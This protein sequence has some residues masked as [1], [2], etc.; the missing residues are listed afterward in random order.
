MKK[1]ALFLFGV[2]SLGAVSFSALA[3][4]SSQ[5]TE[6]VCTEQYVPVPCTNDTVCNQVPCVGDTVCAP[7]PCA[8][9]PCAPGC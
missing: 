4:T 1:L 5:T 7:V 8:P 2:C 9:A 6:P 3:D